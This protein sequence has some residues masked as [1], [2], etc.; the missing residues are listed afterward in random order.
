MF[1]RFGEG[2]VVTNVAAQMC[3]RDKYFLR[4][5][6][7]IP[8]RRI[9]QASSARQQLLKIIVFGQRKRRGVIESVH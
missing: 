9:A 6:D 7:E 5:G 2:A 8:V 3:Q 4:I 1:R